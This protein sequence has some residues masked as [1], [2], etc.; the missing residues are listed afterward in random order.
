MTRRLTVRIPGSTA[1]LGPGFDTLALALSI[2][3]EIT[4]ELVDKPDGSAPV[5]TLSG[6]VEGKLPAGAD[7]L[8]YQVLAGRWRERSDLMERLRIKI[9]SD[10]PLGAGLGSSGTAILAAVWASFALADRE[11]DRDRVL[12]YGTAI[13]GHPDNIAASLNGGLVVCSPSADGRRIVSRRLSWPDEWH[14]LV[15]VPQYSVTTHQARKVLPRHVSL[16]DA[17]ANVQRTALLVSAVAGHDEAAL[18]EALH[19]RLHEPYRSELFPE[20]PALRRV[21]AY[22][23]AIGCVL[24]GAGPSVLVIVRDRHKAAVRE[25]VEAWAKAQDK[26]PR[27]LDL[28]VDKEGL[29]ASHGGNGT[30]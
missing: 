7:N 6:G 11:P 27:L 23:P 22:K 8:V 15:V 9:R 24:S 18:S 25:E 19:D 20:L 16:S 5:V 10:I 1:N 30:A 12:S 28:K 14:T 21:L 29:R 4:F 13:E 17:V 3:T 2:Y 26:P